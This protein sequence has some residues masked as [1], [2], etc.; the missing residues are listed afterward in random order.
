MENR[1]NLKVSSEEY[2]DDQQK[3]EE[4]SEDPPAYYS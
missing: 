1:G 4:I 3:R 2:R